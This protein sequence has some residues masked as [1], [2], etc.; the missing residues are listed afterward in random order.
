MD[1]RQLSEA[2]KKYDKFNGVFA[3]D[4]LRNV[5]FQSGGFVINTD[6]SSQPGEHW[7]AIFI[8]KEGL[9]KYL[10]SFGLPPMHEEILDFLDRVATRNWTYN[11]QPIQSVLS[12]SCGFF[13]YLYLVFRFQ[14]LSMQDFQ[15]FFTN[16]TRINEL[17]LIYYHDIIQL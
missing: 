11:S 4:Q 16:N 3:R 17:L 7:V 8:D 12:M 1:T 2:L 14:G 6:T 10:D 15:D 13:C 5:N 9:V